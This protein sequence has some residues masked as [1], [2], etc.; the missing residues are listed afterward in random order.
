MVNLREKKFWVYAAFAMI[1]GIPLSLWGSWDFITGPQQIW[2]RV[3]LGIGVVIVVYVGL[4][5]LF[6]WNALMQNHW[7]QKRDAR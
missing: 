3:L 6:W 5:L 7:K 2:L 4:V 1:V